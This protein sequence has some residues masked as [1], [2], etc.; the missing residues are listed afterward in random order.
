MFD[1]LLLMSF[2]GPERPEDVMPFLRNVT[3]GRGVPDARLEAVAEHYSHYGGVSPINEQNRRLLAAI[4]ADYAAHGI[5]VKLYWGNRNWDPYVEDTMER[6]R[7]DGVQRAAAFVT[8][9]YGGYSACRQYLE[10]IARARAAVGEG[11]PQIVKLPQYAHRGGFIAPHAEAVKRCLDTIATARQAS[12]RVLYSA[13]SIPTAMDRGSGPGGGL[14]ST[15]LR[16][17]AQLVT[18]RLDADVSWELVWQSRS[19]SS[20][21]PWLEPDI[22]DRLRE[23][24][25]EGVTDVVVSPIGFVSDHVEVLWDLDEEA[26]TTAKEAGLGY[27]RASTPGTDPRF[28][29]LVRELFLETAR[30]DENGDIVADMAHSMG[31]ISE[32]EGRCQTGCCSL[33]RSR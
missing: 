2:G 13:H 7:T 12:T 30:Q 16:R 29:G 1:A 22:N 10:D 27:M 28:V 20:S 32:L 33:V 8:S 26:A 15:Q 25:S 3:R 23:L 4:E 14:Y 9:A 19:G 31:A 5:D 17:A 6:M 24:P 21:V 18:Q 11:A